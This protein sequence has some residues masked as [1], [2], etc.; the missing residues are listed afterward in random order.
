M[1]M[2]MVSSSLGAATALSPFANPGLGTL[3][4]AA[5][6]RSGT[7]QVM[8]MNPKLPKQQVGRVLLKSDFN[9]PLLFSVKLTISN[10]FFTWTLRS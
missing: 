8:Y 2:V 5:E 1:V 9:N 10:R 7:E 6:T 4:G 3:T